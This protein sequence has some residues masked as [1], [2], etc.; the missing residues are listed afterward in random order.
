MGTYEEMYRRVCEK[1]EA[2]FRCL[3]LKIGAIDFRQEL[4]LLGCIRRRF[5]P[6][7]I[8][9]RVDANGAF[10]P[11]QALERLKV[12]GLDTVVEAYKTQFAAYQEAIG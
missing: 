11:S 2:G 3:K 4:D 6:S 12:A 10:P 1:I 7:E 8:E 5:T 9:I